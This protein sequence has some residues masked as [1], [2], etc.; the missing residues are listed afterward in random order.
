MRT[1]VKTRARTGTV[2]RDRRPRNRSLGV[3]LGRGQSVAATQAG[4]RSVAEGVPTARSAVA[5]G[6]RHGVELPIAR[7][8]AA[9]LF[10]GRA[11]AAAVANLMERDLKAEQWR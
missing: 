6:A 8:V 3:E 4:R 9:I 2:V 5:L 11:P 10:E 7:E 1:P